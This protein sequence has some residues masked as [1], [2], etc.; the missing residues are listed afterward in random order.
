MATSEINS[1]L[2]AQAEDHWTTTTEYLSDRPLTLHKAFRGRA[3]REVFYVFYIAGVDDLY[4][5]YAADRV[6]LQ[7]RR[8]FT[9]GSMYMPCD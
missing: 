2:V 8:Y 3:N 5:V 6:Q 7:L 1:V 9:Y 4:A